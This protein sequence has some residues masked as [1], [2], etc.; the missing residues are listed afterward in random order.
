LGVVLGFIVTASA[1]G[2]V[3]W[4]A[5]YESPA[6]TVNATLAGQQGWEGS[7]SGWVLSADGDQ[8]AQLGHSN[9]YGQAIFSPYITA[10]TPG[11]RKFRIAMTVQPGAGSDTDQIWVI[12]NVGSIA[13][14]VAFDQTTGHI[15]A[16]GNSGSWY[17]TG[18][19]FIPA[20]S[21][22]IEIF[23]DDTNYGS[24]IGRTFSLTVN[25][26]MMLRNITTGLGTSGLERLYFVG[27]GNGG[28]PIDNQYV[29]L[30][31]ITVEAIPELDLI[32]Q[33]WLADFE[34]PAYTV[35]AYLTGQQG[36]WRENYSD[37]GWVASFD[38]GQRA[39]IGCWNGYGQV[40]C[41]PWFSQDSSADKRFK[42]SFKIWPGSAPNQNDEIQVKDNS[43]VNAV[44]IIFERSSGRIKAKGYNAASWSDTGIN[45][46]AGM[47]YWLEIY[48]NDNDH[49]FSLCVDGTMVLRNLPCNVTSTGLGYV[50]FNC[51]GNNGVY[52]SGQYAYIDDVVVDILPEVET[53]WSVDFNA[54]AYTTSGFLTG[55]QGWWHT[56][57]WSTGSVI[58]LGVGQKAQLGH[59]NGYGQA[60]CSP[61][62]SADT[63]TDT[64]FRVAMTLQPGAGSDTDH[65]WVVDNM[66]NIAIYVTF[67][68]ATGHIMVKGNSGSWYD[69]GLAFTPTTSYRLEI[70]KDDVNHTFSLAVNNAWKLLSVATGLNSCGID[71]LYFV[72]GGNNGTPIANQYTYLDDLVIDALPSVKQYNWPVGQWD[73]V[74]YPVSIS[75]IAS[76]GTNITLGYRYPDATDE[77]TQAWLDQAYM[78]GMRVILET[79]K[80]TGCKYI[81][82]DTTVV[83]NFINRFKDH[84][85]TYGW[86]IADEPGSTNYTA[87]KAGYDLVK[88]LSSK[89]VFICFTA[90]DGGDP[91]LIYTF[92]A[93]YDIA[94]FD[95][96]PY[97]QGH[98]EFYMMQWSTAQDRI[99][100]AS[101][102]AQQAGKPWWAVLQ[103]HGELLLYPEYNHRLGTW[104]EHRFMLYYCICIADLGTSYKSSV[105]WLNW[106]HYLTKDSLAVASDA[107]PYSG[108]QWL[109]DVYKPL[110]NEINI[111]GSAMS[112]GHKTG[113]S[114][115][116]AT[117]FKRLFQDPVTLE[118]YIIAVNDYNGNRT[119]TFTLSSSLG[120][121][122]Y[123][124]SMFETRSNLAIT[125]RRFV[126][127]FSRFQVHVYKL[128]P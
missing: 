45:Y 12:D 69:T 72:G 92:R 4:S 86:Y 116:Q 77:D 20:A 29:Y 18:L 118:Y 58:T 101:T 61:H 98:T 43:D 26:K 106:C 64:K 13:I 84:P 11:D 99:K 63:T 8:I 128:I 114:D 107:Y 85:A 41:T 22:R 59:S 75:E 81:S 24:G 103:G 25:G 7:S 2:R 73:R 82:S 97:A 52:V 120:S 127:S 50:Y 125:N 42:V 1:Y 3:L 119:T 32:E 39:E 96:Y 9:G 115:N 62:V 27:G 78:M 60:I 57:G 126:D 38:S 111:L 108:I 31:D 89:P 15:M 110:A 76:K 109:S 121:F 40:V 65:I 51:G 48:K 28:V 79:P 67:D 124:Q 100:S 88:T 90:D 23:K 122:S 66:G 87:I 70:L 14:I 91:N 74:D 30:D 47:G 16:K 123:A 6:Y 104:G 95:C 17:D 83:T 34:S 102:N 5:D 113:L 36:W 37:Q 105:G 33:I 44:N 19:T 68:K 112:N 71:F 55:Q 94:L 10:D 93:A 35:N 117:M 56:Q 49:T 21:Y 80:E 46:T 53:L 54:S